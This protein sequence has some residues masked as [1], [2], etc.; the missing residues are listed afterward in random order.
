MGVRDRPMKP[1]SRTLFLAVRDMGGDA[2]M[3]C[4]SESDARAVFNAIRSVKIVGTHAEAEKHLACLE[5]RKV[6][7]HSNTLEAAADVL[8]ESRSLECIYS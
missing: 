2:G 4:V 6:I 3:K 7:A 1:P 5:L 8:D